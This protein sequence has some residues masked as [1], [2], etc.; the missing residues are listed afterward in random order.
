MSDVS[1]NI[2]KFLLNMLNK[3][4]NGV[5]EIGRNV[6][7]SRFNCAPSQINY[8]L[9]TRFTPYRGYYIESRRGGAGYVRIVKVSLKSEKD[10]FK[11]INETIGTAITKDKSI[12]IIESL[13]EHEY[14]DEINARL[15]KHT[16]EDT[17]L[18][19]VDIK[20]RN[21]VRADILRNMLLAFLI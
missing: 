2:E 15:I 12:S 18:T 3:T 11:L 1:N 20:L 13:L 9:S 10:Y 6:L 19:N 21:Y 8:V 16:L 5:L 7:A 14:I 17:S 4:E